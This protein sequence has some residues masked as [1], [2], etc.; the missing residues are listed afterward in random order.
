MTKAEEEI[1][2]YGLVNGLGLHGDRE[3][4]TKLIRRVARAANRGDWETVLNYVV[5]YG[6]GRSIGS[7]ARARLASYQSTSIEAVRW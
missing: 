3:I 4:K 2:A 5:A 1:G 6:L 7:W